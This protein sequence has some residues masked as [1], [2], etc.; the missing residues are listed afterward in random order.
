MRVLWLVLCELVPAVICSGFGKTE[1]GDVQLQDSAP[2]AAF[3]QAAGEALQK[4]TDVMEKQIAQ[5][6]T[7]VGQIS[8]QLNV[9]SA[10]ARQ[11]QD[12]PAVDVNA[13]AHRQA[14]V[15]VTG[16]PKYTFMLTPALQT[17]AAGFR[18]K[19]AH[20]RGI[21]FNASADSASGA[22]ESPSRDGTWD[23]LKSGMRA[24]DIVVHVGSL[25]SVKFGP[26]CAAELRP[27]G[28]YCIRYV[29]RPHDNV[30]RHDRDM[31]E[32][33]AYS[34]YVVGEMKQ[35]ISN[36]DRKPL[37]R[38]VPPGYVPVNVPMPKSMSN[39]VVMLGRLVGGVVLPVNHLIC[40]CCTQ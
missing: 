36:W 4:K 38:F 3:S 21:R 12:V 31:D 24:G 5:L 16:Q 32:L 26:T 25:D 2:D 14:F 27:K 18:S 39:T 23:M 1:G 11:E 13:R 34:N 30:E 22:W 10:V 37:L 7:T 29:T 6:L 28:V 35:S 33:W 17:L 9:E 15:I 20:D 8:K 19:A 40:M